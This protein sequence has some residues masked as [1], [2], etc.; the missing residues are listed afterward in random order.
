ML[1]RRRSDF[2]GMGIGSFGHH[3]G[4]YAEQRS[5]THLYGYSFFEFLL[6]RKL[7]RTVCGDTNRGSGRS[8]R[9]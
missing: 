8:N 9:N 4:V 2:F 5:I 3:R 1:L 6:K 7:K